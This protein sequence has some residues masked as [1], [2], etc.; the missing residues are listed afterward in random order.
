MRED[1][2]LRNH[3]FLKTFYARRSALELNFA[4]FII[5]K[6]SKNQRNFENVSNQNTIL[7]NNIKIMKR[8]S[9]LK[10]GRLTDENTHF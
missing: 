2:F 6:I 10:L 4:I 5:L 9:R 8:E 1:D 3:Q 7:K